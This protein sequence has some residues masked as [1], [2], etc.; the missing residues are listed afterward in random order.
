[1][2]ETVN[3]NT[4]PKQVSVS[5]LEANKATPTSRCQLEQG[6]QQAA[7]REPYNNWMATGEKSYTPAGNMH[8]DKL[9]CLQWVK[10]HGR[11]SQHKCH[12]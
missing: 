5:F 11:V 3:T 6:L 1:M 2:T 12:C 9:L 10:N 7:Y 8:A 4:T